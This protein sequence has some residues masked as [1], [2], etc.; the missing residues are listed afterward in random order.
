MSRLGRAS[1][2]Q[3]RDRTQLV[4]GTAVFAFDP[5]DSESIQH[6]QDDIMDEIEESFQS[7]GPTQRH[8]LINAMNAVHRLNRIS[9]N[10]GWKKRENSHPA[11]KSA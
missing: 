6:A 5:N 8:Q 1:Y 9:I 7:T 4:F 3:R 10:S 2:Q 11:R